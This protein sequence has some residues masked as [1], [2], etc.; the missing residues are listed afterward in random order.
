MLDLFL[1]N[2]KLKI[3]QYFLKDIFLFLYCKM[4]YSYINFIFTEK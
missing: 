3:I 1:N 4:R 2:I